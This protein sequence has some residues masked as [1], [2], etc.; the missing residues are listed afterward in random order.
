MQNSTSII[1][2]FD[3]AV[4]TAGGTALS[5]PIDISLSGGNFSLQLEVTGDG[6]IKAEKKLSNNDVDYLIPKGEE[7]TPLL[8]GVTK[9]SGPGGDGKLIVGFSSDVANQIKFLL[10]ETGGADTVTVTGWLAV[11]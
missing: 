9:T 4:I 11:Q 2:I 10:T 6:T 1:K 7:D 3:A 8:T 5:D